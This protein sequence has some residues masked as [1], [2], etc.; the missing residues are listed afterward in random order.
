MNEY[1]LI[2]DCL[3]SWLQSNESKSFRKYTLEKSISLSREKGKGFISIVLS[4]FLDYHR[5]L[6]DPLKYSLFF[7]QYDNVPFDMKEKYDSLD[8]SKEFL[9]FVKIGRMRNIDDELLYLTLVSDV[10]EVY[11]RDSIY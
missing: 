2:R 3:I 9:F 6:N 7:G 11:N 8:S 10:N 4:N 1:I 5:F